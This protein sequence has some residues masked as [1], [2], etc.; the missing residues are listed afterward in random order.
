MGKFHH[1]FTIGTTFSANLQSVVTLGYFHSLAN[2]FD[3]DKVLNVN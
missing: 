1:N 3:S 2:F